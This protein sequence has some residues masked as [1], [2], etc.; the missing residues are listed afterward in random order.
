MQKRP[1]EEEYE[2]EDDDGVEDD[3]DD[4]VEDEDEEGEGGGG[5]GGGGEGEEKEE[6]DDDSMFTLTVKLF[7]GTSQKIPHKKN[8]KATLQYFYLTRFVMQR[9]PLPQIVQ[10]LTDTALLCSI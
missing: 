7:R 10:R 8:L 4:D 9:S 6:E 2:E 1:E 5:R 3:D